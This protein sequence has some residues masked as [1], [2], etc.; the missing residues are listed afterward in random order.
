MPSG[1]WRRFSTETTS[2]ISLISHT[3]IEQGV[4]QRAER[5]PV[6]DLVG[7]VLAVPAHVRSL[8][9]D[10]RSPER[11]VEAAHIVGEGVG[12]GVQ[13][14]FAEVGAPAGPQRPA[15][16]R[17]SRHVEADGVADQGRYRPSDGDMPTR[18]SRTRGRPSMT[19]AASE[20]V[21]ATLLGLRTVRRAPGSSK[22]VWLAADGESRLSDS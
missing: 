13:D 12:V 18:P 1:D 6:S 19:G 14:R 7:A 10:R 2:L 20:S 9:T 15:G 4:V 16:R 3:D 8:D 11:A 5:E 17:P 21:L 22:I